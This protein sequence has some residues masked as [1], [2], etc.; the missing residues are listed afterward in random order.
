MKLAINFSYPAADLVAS[1]QIPLDRFKTPNW[2]DVVAE[3]RTFRPVA[4]HFNLK[5]GRPGLT[6]SNWDAVEELLAVTGTPHVNVHLAPNVS[7]FPHLALNGKTS[8]ELFAWLVKDLN[9]VSDRFGAERVI[10]EN[11]PY[12]GPED[13][14]LPQGVNPALITRLVEETGTG[15]LLDISHAR[16][17]AHHLGMDA[18][19]YMQALPVD[20]V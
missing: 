4:V 16:I 19:D 14:I 11:V 10:V 7:T 15:L 5:I 12:H 20:R 3:A 9:L 6:E 2:P 13:T 1:G 18:R 8:S 17:A